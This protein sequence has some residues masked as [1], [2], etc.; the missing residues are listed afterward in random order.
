MPRSAL[1]PCLVGAGIAT[2]SAAAFLIRDA[3]FGGA[4][5][6]TIIEE[7]GTAVAPTTGARQDAHVNRD[8]R[9]LEEAASISLWNLLE[10]L[11]TLS[12]P[13]VSVNDAGSVGL[14]MGPAGRAPSS[15]LQRF[16]PWPS[17]WGAR[18]EWQ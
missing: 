13:S 15:I 9:M 8:G 12:D 17:R 3:G 2:L 5:D 1:S 18:L 7:W 10:S 6:I 11:P 14:V 4:T 16:A